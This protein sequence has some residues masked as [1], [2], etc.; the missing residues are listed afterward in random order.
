[1]NQG[2]YQVATDESVGT[3]YQYA[4]PVQGHEAKI[5]NQPIERRS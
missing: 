4:F 3:G 1:V 2:F 5:S